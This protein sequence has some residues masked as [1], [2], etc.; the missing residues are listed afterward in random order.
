[1]RRGPMLG[2]H[3]P[4]VLR[5][6]AMIT[7][8]ICFLFSRASMVA[9]IGL[10]A[11]TVH[12]QS[13]ISHY[14]LDGNG[15]DSG[16]IGVNGTLANSAAYTTN[17]SGVGIF[18]EALSTGDGVNRYF[19]AATANNAAFGVSAI[20]IALWVNIDS[21]NSGGVVDRLVSNATASSGF[22]FTISKS[23]T[24]AGGAE[25]FEFSFA[26]NTT[27]AG[28]I[29]AD[30][31]Y[32]SDKWLFLAVTYDGAN[33]RFY[34]GSETAGLLLN[35]VVAKTGSI[36]TSSSALEI[37]GT[38]ATTNDRSPAALFNDVRIYDGALTSVQLE[39]IRVSAIPEPSQYALIFGLLSVGGIA[40]S[41]RRRSR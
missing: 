26:I 21:A 7:P 36:V 32:V 3:T 10:L 29:S 28:A 9:A 38:T 12:A 4:P 31:Q 16:S 25:L 35:D 20:T 18:N 40:M 1:M 33:I 39:A 5:I 2:F 19:S 6:T 24:G 34:S 27:S 8:R 41:R 23:T 14:T 22:D 17:G 30:A 11:A 13:L 37:G 15:T